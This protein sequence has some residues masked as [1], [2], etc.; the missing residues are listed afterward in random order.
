MACEKLGKA[1][2][3]RNPRADVDALVTRHVGFT[4]FIYEFL[5]SP[6]V[7]ADYAGQRARHKA[8]NK[9]SSVLAREIEKRGPAIDRTLSPENAEYP[10]EHGDWEN[11]T[12]QV[13]APSTYDYPA[14]SL[15]YTPGVRAF[16]MK[17]LGRNPADLPRRE[18]RTLAV[19]LHR[20]HAVADDDQLT[21]GVKMQPVPRSRL[22]ERLDDAYLV[23]VR[24]P[25]LGLRHRP[26]P[27][28]TGAGLGLGRRFGPDADVPGGEA[29]RPGT[30]P[31]AAA[32]TAARKHP[33]VAAYA[34]SAFPENL[35][36]GSIPVRREPGWSEK[37]RKPS[38]ASS[39]RETRSGPGERKL[40]R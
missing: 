18:H 21:L 16:R 31:G 4:Q 27:T 30:C 8:V 22:L 7:M 29:H 24:H 5:R 33:E 40:A 19:R 11:G 32:S 13:L 3:L 37:A 34:S 2:R 10:W 35:V 20:Q 9:T 1:Y 38:G 28:R 17:N 6:A 14:L 12:G 39:A 15:L 23:G 36:R 26:H 25:L